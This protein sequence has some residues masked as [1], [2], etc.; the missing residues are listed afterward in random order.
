MT[1][2]SPFSRVIQR[3]FG[4]VP[5]SAVVGGWWDLNGTLSGCVGAWQ[6]KG[7]AS[8]AA[9]LVN[10]ANPGTFDA[11]AGTA[12]TWD[13]A[14]GWTFNGSSQYLR[15]GLVPLI[16]QSY[17]A[18]VRIYSTDGVQEAYIW[19]RGGTGKDFGLYCNTATLFYGW[20]GGSKSYTVTSI[21]NTNAVLA[22]AGNKS[23]K[24]GSVL[25]GDITTGTPP[26]DKEL[27]L[28]AGNNNGSPA[29]YFTGN[30]IAAAVYSTV[31]SSSVAALTTAMNAL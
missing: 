24:D 25:S 20:N 3:P 7:A 23:Y 8:Y 1:F 21:L 15:T 30:M 27:Y 17:S 13:A 16:D 14:T 6:A 12:P 11:F 29:F 31:I 26:T 22:I 28:G 18:I 4:G 10:L 2:A 9:S 5:S 19:Q